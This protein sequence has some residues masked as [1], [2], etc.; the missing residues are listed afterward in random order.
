[1]EQRLATLIGNAV[2]ASRQRLELTQA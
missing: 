2:R 1:M